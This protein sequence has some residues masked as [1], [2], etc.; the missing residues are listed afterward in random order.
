M[1]N[2]TLLA[3]FSAPLLIAMVCQGIELIIKRRSMKMIEYITGKELAAS[4]KLK[5][6]T[7]KRMIRDGR[8]KAIL[9]GKSYIITNEALEEF[10][11]VDRKPASTSE[12]N[13]FILAKNSAKRPGDTVSDYKPLIYDLTPQGIR[14]TELYAA[15]LELARIYETTSQGNIV[16][17][18][19]N[20]VYRHL[21]DWDKMNIIGAW[22]IANRYEKDLI[23]IHTSEQ[24][25]AE[26]LAKSKNINRILML[27]SR[28]ARIIHNESQTVKDIEP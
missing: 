24:I 16:L 15:L 12:I 18:P 2:Y 10:L 7:I 9:R 6:S 27:Q 22:N 20:I 26:R 21:P 23:I 13:R 19:D 4:L 17:N 28:G 11:T 14:T 8:L 5:Y 3:L 1:Y 25:G